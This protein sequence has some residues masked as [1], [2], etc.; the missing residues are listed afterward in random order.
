MD[1]LKVFDNL[2]KSRQVDYLDGCLS[3]LD[4]VLTCSGKFG[5]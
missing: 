5:D 4:I 1:I 3:G 2:G